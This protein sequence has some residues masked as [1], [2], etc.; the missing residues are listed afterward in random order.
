MHDL[1]L[2]SWSI[3]A[4]VG[5][6]KIQ[7]Y[8]EITILFEVCVHI[9]QFNNLKWKNLESFRML[10]RAVC[11]IIDLPPFVFGIELAT[12]PLLNSVNTV[13]EEKSRRKLIFQRKVSYLMKQ[14]PNLLG[15]LNCSIWGKENAEAI[16]VTSSYKMVHIIY[17]WHNWALLSWKDGVQIVRVNGKRYRRTGTDYFK[18]QI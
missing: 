15:L 5:T 1:D 12:I 7:V 10:Q 4:L 3:Y 14:I 6:R 11:I 9:L 18:H 17:G 2:K 16:H 8:K 13:T